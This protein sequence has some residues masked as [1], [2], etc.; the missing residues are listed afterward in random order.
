MNVGDIS[1]RMS[2]EEEEARGGFL[3]FYE[4]RQQELN[5]E[6]PGMYD[7]QDN[8][9]LLELERR[10]FGGPP[11]NEER[12]LMRELTAGYNQGGPMGYIRQSIDITHG[13]LMY[14]FHSM[15]TELG[16]S[17]N[18]YV[19]KFLYFLSYRF[20]CWIFWCYKDFQRRRLF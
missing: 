6:S 15:R 3:D 1:V 11:S 17:L 18:V 7:T 8:E 4:M 9:S 14:L 16:K 20:G 10:G 2:S 13:R 12:A 5:L 19:K